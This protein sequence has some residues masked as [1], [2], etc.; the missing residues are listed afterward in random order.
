MPQLQP[1]IVAIAWSMSRP[2]HPSRTIHEKYTNRPKGHKLEG[3]VLVGE[4]GRVLRRKGLITLLYYFFR[5]VF[6]D[7]DFFAS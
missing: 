1:S 4:G 2:I 3:F 7:V 5:A 6:P